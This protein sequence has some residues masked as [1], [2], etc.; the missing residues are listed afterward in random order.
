MCLHSHVSIR[1]GAGKSSFTV[2]MLR[3][4]D[5]IDGTITID[6]I[7]TARIT[8]ERLR[9]SIALI[10]QVREM[11]IISFYPFFLG[12]AQRWGMTANF[13]CICYRVAGCN[14]VRWQNQAES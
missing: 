8:R 2:A 6:D 12:L 7:D 1:A 13:T 5:C 10:P 11:G 3:L 14:N 4:A 9:S